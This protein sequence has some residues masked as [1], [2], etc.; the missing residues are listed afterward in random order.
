MN[1]EHKGDEELPFPSPVSLTSIGLSFRSS[2]FWLLVLSGRQA[3]FPMKF[4]YV[5]QKSPGKKNDILLWALCQRIQSPVKI[6]SDFRDRNNIPDLS[7]TSKAKTLYIEKVIGVAQ[8]FAI[9][10]RLHLTRLLLL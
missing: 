4:F 8:Q 10:K 3:F 2:K 9:F 1:K 7:Q 6:F 5:M